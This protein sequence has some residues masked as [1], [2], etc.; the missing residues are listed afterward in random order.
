MHSVWDSVIY[1]WTGVPSLPLS[2]NDW[3]S[4]GSSVAEMEK[5]YSFN[6]ADWQNT[7]A[8]KWAMQSFELSKSSVYAGVTENTSPSDEY[9]SK[10]Q[11][12]IRKQIVLGGLRL[13]YLIQQIFAP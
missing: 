13:G 5:K 12:V 1:L 4:L 7:D 3:Q 8:H 11:D 9:I 10:S 6:S 2:Y